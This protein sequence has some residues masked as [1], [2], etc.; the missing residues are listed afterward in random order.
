V[1]AFSLRSVWLRDDN[2]HM[3]TVAFGE[4]KAV[5]NFSRDWAGLEFVFAMNGMNRAM[6][7][8]DL[9]PFVLT[10][11]VIAKL[12]FIHDLVHGRV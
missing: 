4:L 6:G 10:P 7:N 11:P 5:T 1:E 2:G 9:Y 3:H 12:G 8:R